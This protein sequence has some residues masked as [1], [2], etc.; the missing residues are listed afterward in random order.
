LSLQ[1]CEGKNLESV[2]EEVRHRFG[3]TVTIVEANRLRKGGVGGFFARERFEVV[4][5]IVDDEDA[6]AG[7]PA[8]SVSELP[9]EFG[10]EA[11]ES[12]CERLLSLAD[13]VSDVSD[14]GQPAHPEPPP[15]V[16][17][18]QPEFAAVFE[19]ITR[20]MEA[21]T[22]AAPVRAHAGL[23]APPAPAAVPVPAA[24][25]VPEPARPAVDIAALARLGL[26]EDI[27]R[28]AATTPAPMGAD[29]SAWL[30]GLLNRVP[31]PERLPQGPGSVIVVA[32]GR[33]AA[34]DLAR[35][36][37]DELG[38]DPEALLIASPTYKSRGIPAHRRLATEE[39]AGEARRSWRRR[40]RPTIVAVEAPMGRRGDWARRV[41]DALEPTMVWG[42][43][44]AARKPEDLFE[45]A[46]QLGGFDALAVTDLDGTVSPAAVL[47]CG[48]PVGRLDGRQATPALW[49][50]LLG[51][52][53][54]ARPGVR[55][56]PPEGNG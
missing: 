39:S 24:P 52:R 55:G 54:A 5:D 9:A 28:A 23:S 47:Q 17:T 31:A 11:T 21:Q 33:E 22:A 46:E 53:L 43:L 51:P 29:P 30:L 18:E 32:G 41:I 27:T 50:A 2:L 56:C 13:D 45:W 35:Q 36:L 44:E 3:D 42:A 38:L 19:S 6:D 49:V 12:F 14:H 15:S 25:P 40:P 37:A 8:G 4:V 10:L 7:E 34:L 48:I 26:P 1:R 20:H 16:S